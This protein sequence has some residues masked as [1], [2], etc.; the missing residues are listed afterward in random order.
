MRYAE[1]LSHPG[2]PDRGWT[3]LPGLHESAGSWR[4]SI[5]LA[6][7]PPKPFDTASV[8]ALHVEVDAVLTA[9]DEQ[10]LALTGRHDLAPPP[11]Q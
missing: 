8:V 11:D 1:D 3:R 5:E 2:R 9:A 6:D 7:L 10:R 4:I